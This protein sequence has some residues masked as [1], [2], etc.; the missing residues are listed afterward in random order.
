MR[1]AIDTKSSVSHRPRRPPGER[2]CRAVR[3]TASVRR[4]SSR[5][6]SAVS[7]SSRSLSLPTRSATSPPASP[8]AMS[9]PSPAGDG[10]SFG[11]VAGRSVSEVTTRILLGPV[12]SGGALAADLPAVAVGGELAA[13]VHQEA[14]RAGELVRLPR[15][16]PQ[17][18]LLVGQ[19]RTGQLERLGEVGL[20]DV[21]RAGGL[22]GAPRLQ[23]LE[24]VLPQVVI[25]LARAVAVGSH[26][27]TPSPSSMCLRTVARL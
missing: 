25:G 16:H 13:V 22:V 14:A 23:L 4:P 21:D 17:R 19:V 18:Q 9:W 2:V 12:R 5:R 27:R 10:T 26:V 20:V 15:D 3:R 1:G 6:R 7:M 24:A 11:S 8:G